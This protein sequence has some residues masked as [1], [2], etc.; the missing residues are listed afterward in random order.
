MWGHLLWSAPVAGPR[1]PSHDKD[2]PLQSLLKAKEVCC[3][4]IYSSQ[5]TTLWLAGTKSNG[6]SVLERPGG[7]Q[8]AHSSFLWLSKNYHCSHKQVYLWRSIAFTLL[9]LGKRVLSFCKHSE[10]SQESAIPALQWSAGPALQEC[11]VS[12]L[13]LRPGLP[14]PVSQA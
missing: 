13:F 12:E 6:S 2:G 4:P 3:E 1:S 5:N 7:H 8:E 11:L 14:F 10:H 9:L